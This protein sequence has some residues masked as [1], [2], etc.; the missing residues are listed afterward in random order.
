MTGWKSWTAGLLAIGYG[1]GGLLLGVHDIDQA[2]TS[3]VTG[4]GILGIAHKVDRLRP[5]G[6]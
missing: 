6:S 1:I 2:M 3:V 4:L 5:P